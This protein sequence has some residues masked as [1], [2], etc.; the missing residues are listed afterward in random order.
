MVSMRACGPRPSGSA[1]KRFTTFT[2]FNPFPPHFCLKLKSVRPTPGRP[3]AALAWPLMA[4]PA[5]VLTYGV[6]RV[7]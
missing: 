6:V 4:D 1:S 3:P 5:M 2:Y 7:M